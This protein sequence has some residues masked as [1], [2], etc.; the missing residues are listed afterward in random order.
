VF[1]SSFHISSWRG[2]ER[3]K[4]DVHMFETSVI[5]ER[6][7]AQRRASVLGASIAAH[8]IVIAAVILASVSSTSFPT[9][10]PN[11]MPVFMPVAPIDIPPPRGN[12]NV[13]RQPQQPPQQTQP[14]QH[15]QT[16]PP[17]DIVPATVPNTTPQLTLTTGDAT[18]PGPTGNSTSD[19]WGTPD[20]DPNVIDIGQSPSTPGTGVPD[21]IYQPGVDVKSAIVLHRVQPPYPHAAMVARIPGWVIV[22]C[23]IG[24]TGEVR[25]VEIVKSSM[26]MFEQPAVDALRQWKFAPGYFHGQAVDTYFELKIT[27]EVR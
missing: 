5:R 6:V 20:G 25:D 1:T 3:D 7:A 11:E 4:E 2:V 26:V 13:P 14:A 27:F 19:R 12:P 15:A 8:S 24:K 21:V 23:V 22:K 17:Q 18:N 16:A 9:K 10:A